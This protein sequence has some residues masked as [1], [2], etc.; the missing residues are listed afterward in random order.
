MKSYPLLLA[1]GLLAAGLFATDSFAQGPLT[2]IG[3]PAP[4]MKT[5]QQVEPR[6][7][8]GALPFNITNSGSYY[9]TANLTGVSGQGGIIISASHVTID[10]AGF[11]MSGVAGSLDAVQ[12][13]P[14]VVNATILNG[15]LANWG[16][17]GVAAASA[18][19]CRFEQLRVLG[20]GGAG[21]VCGSN[22]LVTGCT[23]LNQTGDGVVA[24]AASRITDNTLGAN[25]GSPTSAG[26]R[27]SGPG[28]RIEG[29][30]VTG[31]NGFGFCIEGTGNLIVRN[32]ARGTGAAAYSIIAGNDFGQIISPG[33][34]FTNDVP[35]AN[36]GAGNGAVCGNGILE[37]GETCDDAN[38]INGD[39][40][41]AV[42]VAQPGYSCT[43][44]PSVC[45][46][47]CGDGVTTSSEQCDDGN[48]N[49]GDGCSAICTVE[50]GYSCS[51]SPSVCSTVCGDGV[52]DGPESCDD[53]NANNGDGCSAICTVE[54][55]YSCS[56]SPS[57]CSTVCG[58]GVVGGP[59]S[60]DDGNATN[61]DGCSAICTVEA[62]YSCTG[63]PS[64]CST[65][66]GDGVVGGPESCDDG[67]ATN[68]DGCSAICTVEAGY[69]CSGSPS[70][71]SPL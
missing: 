38:T 6:T 3:A 11:T 58:D 34:N 47:V 19:S 56:G 4:T 7:P 60:C 43:G 54:A 17:N 45:V 65:V 68:G 14:G 36:F 21:L 59:E 12:L 55:G 26:L 66:C 49:N 24:G 53:G 20:N 69:S 35:W 9:L 62:G 2:P 52:V 32:S 41:T 40:C 1:T 63:A 46:T 51:G 18:S 64:V 29:N 15:A 8:I 31:G 57:V 42:C 48:T 67:N 16:G 22:A 28:S 37:V 25:G 23:I 33:A 30:H 39:G 70:V 50:A 71:C 27:I 5:L 44:A 13:S 10:L 61:G